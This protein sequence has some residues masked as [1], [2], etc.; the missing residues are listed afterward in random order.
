MEQKNITFVLEDED[1]V[2][3]AQQHY[4][5]KLN[6]NVREILNTDNDKFI[7]I[8]SLIDLLNGL[9]E[10]PFLV[11]RSLLKVSIMLKMMVKEMTLELEDKEIILNNQISKLKVAYS[12]QNDSNPYHGKLKITIESLNSLIDMNQ[13]VTALR[14]TLLSVKNKRDVIY[15]ISDLVEKEL[16]IAKSLLYTMT[17]NPELAK[18][19]L[20]S[21]D[22]IER[23]TQDFISKINT[24]NDP[25]N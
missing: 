2:L 3:L 11:M 9:T 10:H 16:D 21:Q 20:L 15:S 19:K 22:E 17:S 8:A 6:I 24:K 1:M 13:S 12:L 18:A 5:E 14:R 23:F 7:N 4:V 25:E